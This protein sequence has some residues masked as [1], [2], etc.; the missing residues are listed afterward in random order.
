MRQGQLSEQISLQLSL[1]PSFPALQPP[2]SLFGFSGAFTPMLARKKPFTSAIVGALV[3]LS[4]IS[5][6]LILVRVEDVTLPP[7]V[8]VSQRRSLSPCG[9]PSHLRQVLQACSCSVGLGGAMPGPAWQQQGGCFVPTLKCRQRK[10]RGEGS[11][12]TH[13]LLCQVWG[14]PW[15]RWVGQSPALLP[16]LCQGTSVCPLSLPAAPSPSLP[17]HHGT[18]IPAMPWAG[19]P[20][21]AGGAGRVW[22]SG[23]ALWG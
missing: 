10:V 2:F 8:K 17:S 23:K 13:P 12:G 16:V 9:E 4:I 1:T 15:G 21:P 18:S 20:T 14:L 22:V 6:V 3:A 7:T 11:S 5:L 19:H